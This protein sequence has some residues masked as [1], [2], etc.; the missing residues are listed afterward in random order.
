MPISRRGLLTNTALMTLLA[1]VLRRR[2]AIAGTASPRRVIL[3]YNGNGP[4]K[5]AGPVASARSETDFTLHE[6]WAPLERHKSDGIFLS[7]MAATG[8]GVVPGNGH[9]LGGQLFGGWGTMP[10]ARGGYLCNGATIDQV[11]GKRL[12][13]EGRAGIA[14]SVNWGLA[15]GHGAFWAGPGKAIA[16]Q[17]DPSV[18]WADL[19]GGF[20]SAE[21]GAAGATRLAREKSILD[22]VNRDCASVRDVLG[23]EGM[24]LLDDHCTTVRSMEKNLRV[25]VSRSMAACRKASAPDAPPAGWSDPENV[26]A[27]MSAFVGLMATALVCELTHLI[28]FQFSGQASRNRIAGSYDVPSSPLANSGDSGPAHHPWTHQR[29]SESKM[30]AL[31]IFNRFYSH[32]VA[33][34]LDKLKATRDAHGRPLLDSTLVVWCQELGGSPDNRDGHQTGQLPVILFG[35]GLGTFK[36]GRYRRGPSPE[37]REAGF[38][39]LYPPGDSRYPEYVT[40]NVKAGQEMAKLL[41]SVV[42]YMGLRDVDTVGATG[43]KGP[44]DWLH[45]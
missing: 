36:T 5:V 42:R 45:A 2:D 14:R 44:L 37:G 35:N 29:D 41:V 38:S 24:R 34:L 16:P 8:H 13:A 9:G 32:H 4:M 25:E 12:L 23:K 21:P 39:R 6:W 43:V 19:F 10:T 22:F 3:L 11:I 27:Q 20:V 31:G 40:E 28:A 7:H 1:P 15:K 33:V 30:N 17:L 26:D 18:A